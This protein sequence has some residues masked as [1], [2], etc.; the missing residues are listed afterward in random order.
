MCGEDGSGATDGSENPLSSP[1]EYGSACDGPPYDGVPS[2][3]DGAFDDGLRY[4]LSV[5]RSD[6]PDDFAGEEA[7]ASSVTAIAAVIA[8]ALLTLNVAAITRPR[9]IRR[10]RIAG[11]GRSCIDPW[12]TMNV[13]VG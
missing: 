4:W 5:V 3:Y 13:R 1:F 6:P 11:S 9:V 10:R 7:A 12:S 2:P 8:T